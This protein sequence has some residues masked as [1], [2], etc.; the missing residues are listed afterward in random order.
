MKSV[1]KT[2]LFALCIS[3]LFAGCFEA[4]LSEKPTQKIDQRL[5]G[6]WKAPGESDKV[7]VDAWDNEY[8]V[9]SSDDNLYRAFHSHIGKNQFLTVEVLSGSRSEKYAYFA[10]SLSEDGKRLTTKAVSNTLFPKK[11]KSAS[12]ARKIVEENIGR[13]ELYEK[14]TGTLEKQ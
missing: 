3:V 1:L 7:I 5:I 4:P 10:W 14:E 9:I 11:L 6:I 13:I 2:S 8:Y 12:E